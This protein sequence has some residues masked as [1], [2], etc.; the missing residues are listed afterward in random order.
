RAP[1]AVP[2]HLSAVSGGAESW[3]P[4]RAT[5]RDPAG[6]AGAGP[7]VAFLIGEHAVSR[8]REARGHV[9]G[10]GAELVELVEAAVIHPAVPLLVQRQRPLQQEF[11]LELIVGGR[12]GELDRGRATVGGA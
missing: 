6:V 8:H 12:R 2:A 10:Q 9:L 1:G 5:A 11:L 4:A 3:S 7:R